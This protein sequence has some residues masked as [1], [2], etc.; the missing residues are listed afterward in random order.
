M[1]PS[2]TPCG[3][4]HVDAGEH[5]EQD[6]VAARLNVVRYYGRRVTGGGLRRQDDDADDVHSSKHGIH[7]Q[8]PIPE[9][10]VPQPPVD[11]LGQEQGQRGEGHVQ[12]GVREPV[13]EVGEEL[14]VVGQVV[15]RIVDGQAPKQ[16]PQQQPHD[17]KPVEH[18][19]V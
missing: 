8:V 18:R 11:D 6:G 17:G 5:K 3:Y 10:G 14:L 13:Q 15:Q 16:R 1:L 2:P 7:Q 12:Q 4:S 9:P 19:L